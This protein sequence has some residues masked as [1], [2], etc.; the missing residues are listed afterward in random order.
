[1]A[2]RALPSPRRRSGVVEDFIS[3][4]FYV[5]AKVP[6]GQRLSCRDVMATTSEHRRF[7][8]IFINVGLVA[9][10]FAPTAPSELLP[11]YQRGQQLHG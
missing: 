4:G 11:L 9:L 2:F 6:I 10:V 5:R 3:R 1:M 8:M 7:D